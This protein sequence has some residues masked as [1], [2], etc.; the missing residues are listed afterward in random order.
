[1]KLAALLLAFLPG[2]L[3]A[4]RHVEVDLEKQRAV[5]ESSWL[6]GDVNLTLVYNPVTKQLELKWSSNTNLDVAGQV[7][8][9]ESAAAWQTVGGIVDLLKTAGQAYLVSQGVHVPAAAS[10]PSVA[11]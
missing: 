8:Q 4:G 6:A 9:A 7:R 5:Y 3:F 2:C 11:R 10:Q 1:M